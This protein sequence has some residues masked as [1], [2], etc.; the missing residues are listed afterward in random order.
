[1]AGR[2][3][4][5]ENTTAVCEGKPVRFVSVAEGLQ[6]KKEAAR[7]AASFVSFTGTKMPNSG[8]RSTLCWRQFPC[9]G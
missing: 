1:M 4:F 6:D 3:V 8:R 9:R 2:R 5:Y 7:W